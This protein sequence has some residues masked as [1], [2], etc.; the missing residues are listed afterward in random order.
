MHAR[1]HERTHARTHART[2]TRTHRT[3]RTHARYS[4]TRHGHAC[5]Y[6]GWKPEYIALGSKQRAR[7]LFLLAYFH[8][9]IQERRNY[10]PQGWTEA[11][12]FSPADLR[13]AS[14]VVEANLGPDAVASGLKLQWALFH[15]MLENALY[16]G[17]ISNENDMR[18]L[19]AYEV[20]FFND[21]MMAPGAELFK[22]SGAIPDST[23][24][25]DYWDFIEQLPDTDGP[26]VFGLP[27][28]I[29][30][31]SQKT[32]SEIILKQLKSLEASGGGAAGGFDRALWRVMLGP[33][34]DSWERLSQNPAA[35]DYDKGKPL[36]DDAT[37]VQ[38]FVEMEYNNAIAVVQMVDADVRAIRSVVY[39]GALV[40]PEVLKNAGTM[41][42][43]WVP[44]KWERKWEGPEAPL[45]WLQA[46]LKRKI[47][48]KQWRADA[49]QAPKILSGPVDL[50]HLLHP[51]TF[52][53]GIRQ[54]TARQT[55]VPLDA[56]KQISCW[57]RRAMPSEAK[58]VVE[59]TGLLLQG[60]VFGKDGKLAEAASDE[61]EMVRVDNVFIA[62]VPPTVPG[63]YPDGQYTLTPVYYNTL[64]ERLLTSVCVPITSNEQK[65][66]RLGAA[67]F[68]KEL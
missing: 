42:T 10:I 14:N 13:V 8:A 15:G 63:C 57:D 29:E 30:R 58:V 37:P 48:L 43:G 36:P 9:I 26:D 19:R 6:T 50:G 4:A 52:L 32:K 46:L 11:Y 20:Q 24:H 64:R 66:V 68:I 35:L 53:N 31:A 62:F 41:M 25:A 51:G 5:R 7:L 39:D 49:M 55:G 16:G 3:H 23:S 59:V 44:G 47:A 67:L 21:A 28:N 17:R 12:E 45:P 60:C 38:L 56:L 61:L 33:S 27:R 1:T 34:L 65:W 54:Q 2:H 40:T 18:V 22:G